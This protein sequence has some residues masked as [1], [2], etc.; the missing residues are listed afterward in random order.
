MR[1]ALRILIPGLLLV[2]GCTTVSSRGAWQHVPV[3]RGGD[4]QMRL[5]GEP[6]LPRVRGLLFGSRRPAGACDSSAVDGVCVE[7]AKDPD[8][9][10][11]RSCV[12]QG[13]TWRARCPPDD[14]VAR[15]EGGPGIRY[16][17]ANRASELALAD[18]CPSAG[19]GGGVR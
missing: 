15:C 2:G 5:A 19:G 9:E 18:G 14:V 11:E 6:L 17:Y 13:G 16:V 1:R 3:Q 12:E 7:H 8:A 10:T 4:G